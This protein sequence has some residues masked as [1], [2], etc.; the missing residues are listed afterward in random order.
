MGQHI[1]GYVISGYYHQYLNQSVE[2]FTLKSMAVH[3]ISTTYYLYDIN[4]CS[5]YDAEVQVWLLIKWYMAP[6]INMD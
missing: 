4:G 6:I 5:L 1:E 3:Q 2:A